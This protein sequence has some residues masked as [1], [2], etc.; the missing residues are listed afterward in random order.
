M[1]KLAIEGMNVVIVM[2][3]RIS[4]E[5]IVTTRTTARITRVIVVG[6]TSHAEVTDAR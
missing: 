1:V 2:I 5:T 6:R 3:E 4:R